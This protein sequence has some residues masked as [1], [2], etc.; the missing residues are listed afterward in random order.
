LEFVSSREARVSVRM[1]RRDAFGA[2]AGIAS[3][4]EDTSVP[5]R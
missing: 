5:S 3:D 1:G 2:D 4:A